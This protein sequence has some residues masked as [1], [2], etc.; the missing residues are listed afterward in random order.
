MKDP[1]ADMIIAIKNAGTMKKE[2]VVFTHSKL[3][4]AILETLAA[5]GFIASV[6][7]KGKKVIKYIEV[8]L[9]YDASGA[10]KIATT[11]RVSKTSKRVYMK[12]NEIHSVRS[13]HGVMILST[14]K[15]ILTD[16]AA[17]EAKVGGEALFSIW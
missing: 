12:A 11:K 4:M 10:P 6:A 16:K 7:K 3:K 13:G 9:A 2:S 1:I 15:G 14:P 17:R 8:K 5:A